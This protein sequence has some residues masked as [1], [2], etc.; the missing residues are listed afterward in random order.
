MFEYLKAVH[1]VNG[2][3]LQ[4]RL[5]KGDGGD[6]FEEYVALEQNVSGYSLKVYKPNPNGDTTCKLQIFFTYTDDASKEQ[7]E[8]VIYENNYTFEWI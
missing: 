3:L 2:D 4:V 6:E 5:V 8:V 1:N 7:K